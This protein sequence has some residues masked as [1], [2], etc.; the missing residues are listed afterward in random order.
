MSE[1]KTISEPAREI[2]VRCEVDVL[3]V[4]GGPAGI[5]AAEAA[6]ESGARTMLIENRG[7]WEAIS[8]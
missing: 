3:V 2:P 8:R 7:F 5:M 1:I 6:A 4:G